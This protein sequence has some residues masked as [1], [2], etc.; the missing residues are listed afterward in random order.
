MICYTSQMVPFAVGLYAECAKL[1]WRVVPDTVQGVILDT[2]FGEEAISEY[3]SRTS[4]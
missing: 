2:L 3:V 1:C 4:V